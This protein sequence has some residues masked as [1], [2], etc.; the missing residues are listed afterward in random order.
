MGG[1]FR[2]L[3]PTAGAEFKWVRGSL[4]DIF[5][6]GFPVLG[7][8]IALKRARTPS[9]L[10]KKGFYSQSLCECLLVVWVFVYRISLEERVCCR[11]CVCVCVEEGGIST[12][13]QSIFPARDPLA[14]T[15]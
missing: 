10:S 5:T 1:V 3:Y 4:L 13:N 14:T 7:T 15:Y 11:R 12:K 2:V 6:P 9:F 8:L